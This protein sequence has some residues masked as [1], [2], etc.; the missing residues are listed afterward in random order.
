MKAADIQPQRLGKAAPRRFR[1][2]GT[3]QGPAGYLGFGEQTDRRV[4]NS[5]FGG[6]KWLQKMRWTELDVMW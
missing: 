3:S 5:K 4:R 1:Y 2:R 6:D